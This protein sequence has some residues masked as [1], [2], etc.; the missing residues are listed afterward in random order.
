M[1]C[2]HEEQSD[3]DGEQ[4]VNQISQGFH[5]FC[6]YSSGTKLPILKSLAMLSYWESFNTDIATPVILAAILSSRSCFVTLYL[7]HRTLRFGHSSGSA[8]QME[9]LRPAVDFWAWFKDKERALLDGITAKGRGRDT[10]ASR[11][12]R[13]EVGAL[14][15]R[16][17]LRS[18]SA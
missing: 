12:S 15:P 9:W 6:G 11:Q 16:L 17:L 18:I 7:V 1:S 2:L 5:G 8:P 13:R 10:S 4:M 3:A 14:T